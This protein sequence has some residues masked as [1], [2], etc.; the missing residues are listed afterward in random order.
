[1]TEGLSKYL[2]PTGAV[3]EGLGK[4]LKPIPDGRPLEGNSLKRYL[5]DEDRARCAGHEDTDEKK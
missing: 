5:T 3:T 2:K 4:Y 1:M